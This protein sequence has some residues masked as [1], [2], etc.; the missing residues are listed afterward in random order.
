[1][2]RLDSS[3]QAAAISEL[4]EALRR[5]AVTA[6][7]T[8]SFGAVSVNLRQDDGTYKVVADVCPG[9]E[10]LGS[11][12]S[13]AL[14]EAL[15]AQEYKISKSY[16]LPPEHV[17]RVAAE[18]ADAH[19]TV[20]ELPRADGP[21]DWDRD[22]M[23]VVPLLNRRGDTLG[24][25]SVDEPCDGKLPTLEA[26]IHL[27]TFAEH[28]ALA[29]ENA[30]LFEELSLKVEH[31]GALLRISREI[32]SSLD[33]GRTLE[34]IVNTTREL[35]SADIGS[36]MLVN[37]KENYLG[38]T[39][40][41]Q[42]WMDVVGT[43]TVKVGEGL[44]GS[45]ALT[46]HPEVIQDVLGDPRVKPGMARRF[47]VRSL[48]YVPILLDG[49]TVGVLGALYS[50]PNAVPAN[51]VQLMAP[52]AAQAA[53]ALRN[54]E[55]YNETKRYADR[56]NLVGAI[57]GRLNRINDLQ[58]IGQAI[59][60]ELQSLIDYHACRV[61]VVSDARLQPIALHREHEEYSTERL[62]EFVMDIGQGIT[63]YVALHGEGVLLDNA[64]LDPR[65]ELIPG[66]EAY[67]E[68]MLVVPIRYE[69][70]IIGVISLSKLGLRQFTQTDLQVLSTLADQAATAIENA[71]LF[72]RI[73]Q[74]TEALRQSEE[75][76]RLVSRATN[77]AIWDWNVVTNTLTWNPALEKVFGHR[78]EEVNSGLK[79]LNEHIHPDDRD[80]VA[81]T[82]WAVMHSGEEF[83]SDEYRFLRA[84]G[85]YADVIDRGYIVRDRDGQ[86]VRMIGS[87]MDIS[88]RKALEEALSYQAFHDGLTG[89]PNRALFMDRLEHAL[90]R[91]ERSGQTSAV[92][93][94]DLDGFKAV[95]DSFGHQAGDDLLISV[96][97]RLREC[98]RPEDTIARLSGDEFALLLEDVSQPREAMRVADRI[99][100]CLQ[101]PFSL[102]GR[103]IF[104]STSIGIALST[105]AVSTP[106]GLLRDADIAMYRAKSRGRARYEVFEQG[107]STL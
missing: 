99:T 98:L 51:S 92:L 93:F 62:E 44:V 41:T 85:A 60:Q 105:P 29:K 101:A 67:D 3:D 95:N 18:F 59:A 102:G 50:R 88:Q 15:L 23:L 34:T 36:L 74:E 106:V 80:R 79:W 52:I 25:F 21:D 42:Q 9:E 27:E 97:H 91:A 12:T 78:P 47:N 86:P 72:A 7:H 73:E 68:S 19:W 77:D 22:H 64:G 33:P 11:V 39:A 30:D 28:A 104:I 58:S 61:Y 45:V 89:L 94:L 87:I 65:V 1:M 107:T 83:W 56:L 17:R 49:K 24:Y 8:L 57:A 4:A 84:D 90:A 96:T 2:H 40:A 54:S 14:W 26:I 63:G 53:L 70:R 35:L 20:P 81:T 46:G 31:L 103:E 71:R 55:L 100:A 13:P 48:A 82:M 69:E 6:T 43:Q 75:R 10:L 16:L 66:T 32:S 5:L 37:E 76:Y 38:L